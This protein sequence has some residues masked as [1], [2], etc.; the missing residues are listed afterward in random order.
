M[1]PVYS[2]FFCANLRLY[3][4]TP[5]EVHCHHYKP[6]GLEGADEFENLRI[7]HKDVHRLYMQQ[8]MKQ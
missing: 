4:L 2:T 6:V 7:L 1:V 5:E 3:M 8:K